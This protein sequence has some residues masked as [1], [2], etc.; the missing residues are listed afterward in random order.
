MMLRKV[1]KHLPLACFFVIIFC[2]SACVSLKS[3]QKKSDDKYSGSR[4]LMGSIF[5]R[6]GR[7]D[8]KY[9]QQN[10][11]PNAQAGDRDSG[12]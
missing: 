11:S 12:P 9:R 5:P 6:L 3:P 2:R 4:V 7:C 8:R 1:R 10:L